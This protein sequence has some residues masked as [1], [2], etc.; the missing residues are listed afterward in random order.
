MIQLASIE[1]RGQSDSGPFSGIMSLSSGLQVISAH[2]S[3]GKSLAA[4]AVAWCLGLEPLFG[5]PDNNSTCFPLAA[6]EEVEFEGGI[7]ARVLSSECGISL[8]HSDGRHLRLSRD[9]KGDPTIIRVEERA[10]D[11]KIRRSKMESRR[12]TMQDEHGGLQRFLFEWLEWPRAEVATFK[13][14]IADVYL[15]NLAGLFYIEQEE[16]WTDLQAR[17]ISRYAQQQIAQVA[18]E[19]L[20]G[21]TDAVAG[22]VAQQNAILRAAGLRES[23]HTI[24]DRVNAVF[25]RRGWSVEWSGFGS[26]EEILTR[27]SARTILEALR[28]EADA[29]LAAQRVLLTQRA[30]IL[31]RA[32]TSDP[33]DPVD[34]SAHASASQKVIA[35]KRR[36]HDLSDELSTLRIQYDQT[37]ELL[38]S[39]EHRIHS[40]GDVLRLKTTGVGRLE[41][42]ECPTCHRDLDPAT[43]ALTE[44]SRESVAAHIEALKRDRKLI[45]NNLQGIIVRLTTVRS[46]IARVEADFRDA[47]WALVTVTEAIGTVREQLAQTA[48]NLTAV[49]REIDRLVATAAELD[50]LQKAVLSW[51]SEAK[52]IQ[53]LITSTEDLQ[54]RVEVFT[55]EL[56]HYLLA[57][58]HSAVNFENAINVR[59]DDQYVPFLGARRLKSLGSASDRPRLVAAYSLA[60]AA[61]S[62]QVGGLHP[63]VVILDEPLQQNP[64]DSHRDLFSTFLSKQRALDAHFQV[65]VFTFLRPAEIDLLRERGTTVITPKGEHFLKLD[66]PPAELQASPIVGGKDNQKG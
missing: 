48:A 13:G 26:V 54:R 62:Q 1:I 51:I 15:E 44:Q 43:F 63:G 58:G 53:L 42:V 18:V 32:L 29:D 20:L 16:G 21:A 5:V 59:I 6:R 31:R 35:L 22:R 49:E 33:I 24:A 61:A 10:G 7:A 38:T 39:L 36:R 65:V 11:G 4:K 46:E 47:E 52:G 55:A 34:A 2:N 30:E 56:R 23:A 25:A 17:Q 64:D 45:K 28:Q 12:K 41:Q 8:L 37:E 40:A 57:L 14:T 3:Y 60:L 50:D 66:A 19:Y 27:W 9:I